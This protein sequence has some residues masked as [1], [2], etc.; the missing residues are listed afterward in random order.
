MEEKTYDEVKSNVCDIGEDS[1]YVGESD[2]E[3]EN[4][5]N[6]KNYRQKEIDEITLKL[7]S[8]HGKFNKY[9]SLCDN[10]ENLE[11][12]KEL[13]T[14]K[15]F[16]KQRIIDYTE[17]LID[18]IHVAANN[19]IREKFNAYVYSVIKHLEYDSMLEGEDVVKEEE[20]DGRKKYN[21][22]LPFRGFQHR[23]DR[24]KK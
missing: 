1:D 4:T 16:F 19:D 8:N 20:Y 3:S 23:N 17:E 13:N 6:V 24:Y 11:S 12:V 22:P 7:L 5:Y 18:N 10:G 9:L 15:A 2:D 21:T 14:K